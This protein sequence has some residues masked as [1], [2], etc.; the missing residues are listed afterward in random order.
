LYK[1]ITKSGEEKD[2]DQSQVKKKKKKKVADEAAVK[3]EE[4]V[5]ETLFKKETDPTK[6][7][8]ALS[9]SINRQTIIGVLLMLMVL[10]LLRRADQDYSGEHTLREVFWFGRSNCV[11]GHDPNAFFCDHR[12]WITKEGWFETLRGLVS[13]AMDDSDGERVYKKKLLWVYAPDFERNG[14]IEE[15]KTIP[16]RIDGFEYPTPNY[17]EQEENCSG[18][19]VGDNCEW[20]FEEMEIISY[21]PHQC[22]LGFQ[23][24]EDGNPLKNIHCEHL[25]A[26]ARF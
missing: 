25:V 14:A 12:D 5:E 3:K 9:E 4:E 10:P 20:R 6:L 13:S 23:E 11:N 18:F 2:E 24:D 8:K 26:Y 1:Y 21:T 19:K 15:I 7:G 22:K 17:W 16:N